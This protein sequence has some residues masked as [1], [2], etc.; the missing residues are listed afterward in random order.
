[1]PEYRRNYFVVLSQNIKRFLFTSLDQILFFIF[2]NNVL[3]VQIVKK[4]FVN[5]FFCALESPLQIT[6]SSTACKDTSRFTKGKAELKI[7]TNPNSRIT[8]SSLCFHCDNPIRYKFHKLLHF[9]LIVSK[10]IT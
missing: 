5:L 9:I 3:F 8:N 2:Y 4:I 6:Q 1:M 7:R 10:I